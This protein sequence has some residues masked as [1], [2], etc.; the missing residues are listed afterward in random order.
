LE[1]S[2]ISRISQEGQNMARIII[3][4]FSA[5][6]L[7]AFFTLGLASAGNG[8]WTGLGPE[9]GR[10]TALAIDPNSPGTIYA[11]TG[12]S[13]VFKT[14]NG[15]SQW[16]AVNTGLESSLSNL[17]IQSLAI[18]ATDSQTIYAATQGGMF[19]STNGGVKWSK[20]GSIGQ[21]NSLAIDPNSPDTIY[22]GTQG[23]VFSST[24]GGETWT[25][26]G[27]GFLSFANAS[28]LAIAP[29]TPWTIYAGTDSGLFQCTAA[30]SSWSRPV[31]GSYIWLS[32]NMI[33]TDP[34]LP[35][36][37]YAATSIY[38]SGGTILGGV[39]KSING[40]A[41]SR[42]NSIPGLSG[43][44]SVNSLAIDATDSQTIYIGTNKGV[45]ATSDGGVNWSPIG[46]TGIDVRPLAVVSGA[47]FAGTN[48]GGIFKSTDSGGNWAPVNNGLIPPII[49]SLAIDPNSPDTIYAGVNV[50]MAFKSPDGGS[51]WIP[52]GLTSITKF[53]F[54]PNSPD[55]IYAA[56][57]ISG[58]FKSEDSGSKWARLR[59]PAPNVSTLAI[60]P[61]D[62]Q[63]IYAGT[64][65]TGGLYKSTDGGGTWIKKSPT[66]FISS[67]V[68]NP[69]SHETI[70][71]G[72]FGGVSKST[73]GGNTWASVFPGAVFALAIDPKDSQIIYASAFYQVLKSSDGGLNWAPTGLIA[74]GIYSLAIDPN[75]PQTIYVGTDSEGV[76]E[77]I[78]GG[79][80]WH[81]IGLNEPLV[82]SL[83]VSSTDPLTIY[84]G[85]CGGVWSYSVNTP[86]GTDVYVQPIDTT[87]GTFPVSLVFDNVTKSGNTIL[88]I[89]SAGPPPPAGF[90]VADPPIYYGISTSAVYTPPITV[91]I[92]YDPTQYDDPSMLRLL[93]YE[94]SAWV[95]TTTSNDTAA[96]T[97][98]G[99]ATS[100]S[101]FVVAQSLDRTAPIISGLPDSGTVLW[102]PNNKMV[103]VATIA[104]SDSLSGLYS[105][106]VTATSNEPPDPNTPDIV[107]TGSGL[108]PR[109]V[110]LRAQRLGAG[111]GRIYTLT[112]TATDLAG[113]TSTVTTKVMVPHDQGK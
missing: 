63:T 34:K 14:T 98:C 30:G 6:I 28:T 52:T 83:A 50:G 93:H 35:G 66:G 69:N 62:S 82:R 33:A 9:G 16:S 19:K 70:Y 85:S 107:I 58:I 101:P 27:T 11:G 86:A 44:D 88:T 97:I 53:A 21:V 54:D 112:A 2:Q 31:G 90:R 104:A 41:W 73:D 99:Q 72:G 1:K 57:P 48:G 71:A 59:T 25:S 80:T 18:D 92:I 102:P 22:A 49:G 91:C 47:I 7:L 60:D 113:N 64:N 109:T 17:Y 75:S 106:N 100:L 95:N 4:I 36:I 61:T 79:S 5:A 68:I 23:G 103:K 65:W 37:I 55:T 20:A 110:Q 12:G 8:T 39:F 56:S 78:D 38:D 81:S 40:S 105:F 76:F 84:A 94:N 111:I 67:L 10:I 46:M 24:D 43:G 26:F 32:T 89:S 15:G 29:T 77:S 13:G 3:R 87:T 51:S 42:L 108:G 74:N 96:H 45:F